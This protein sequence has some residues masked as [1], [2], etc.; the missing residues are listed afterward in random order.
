MSACR[1]PKPTLPGGPRWSPK[2]STG[3]YGPCTT[4]REAISF[5]TYFAAIDAA[6]DAPPRIEMPVVSIPPPVRGLSA[7]DLL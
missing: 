2:E 3:N 5:R 6:P 4:G 7:L 1:I